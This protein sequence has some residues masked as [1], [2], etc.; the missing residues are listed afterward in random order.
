MQILD[1]KIAE[2]IK[3]RSIAT[4]RKARHEALWFALDA[5]KAQAEKFEYLAMLT[6]AGDG[7]EIL[8]E[9]ANALKEL[10]HS[11]LSGYEDGGL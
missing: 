1:K 11:I 9:K 10:R 7:K 4:Q 3:P 5:I 2:Q 8:K 6:S